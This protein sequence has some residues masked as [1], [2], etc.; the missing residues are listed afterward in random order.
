M[1]VAPTIPTGEPTHAVAGDTWLW[2]QTF[3]EYPS[4]EGWALSYAFRGASLLE[5]TS[6]EVSYS[7]TTATV[8]IAASRTA[9]LTPGTYYWTA[10]ATGSGSYAG[11]VHT[12]STG[13]L[14]VTRNLSLAAEGEALTWEEQTLSVVEAALT[15]K[16]TDDMASYMIA[17]RQVVTIPLNELRSLRSS[18]KR[19]I[20]RQRGKPFAEFKVVC[21]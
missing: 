16:V 20:A 19:A 14:E 21:P 8:T 4:S 13:V 5:T 17:G 15:G 11:R 1:H 7:G 10:T 3:G 6:G 18:L 2:T 12:A 9:D